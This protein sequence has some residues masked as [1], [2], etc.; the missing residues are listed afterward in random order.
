MN[1]KNKPNTKRF[2]DL[3][4]GKKPDEELYSIKSDPGQLINIAENP[5]FNSALKR[6]RTLLNKHL[7]KTKDSRALGLDA[8][9]DYYPYYGLKRNNNWKVDKS[10]KFLLKT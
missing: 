10:V 8:P 5:T 1:G 6:M 2:Y 4:F 7:I 9:W 3:A